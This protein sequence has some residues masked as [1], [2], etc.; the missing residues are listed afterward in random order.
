MLR[1]VD[2]HDA[3]GTFDMQLLQVAAAQAHFDELRRAARVAGA[4][5]PS[6]ATSSSATPTAHQQHDYVR[7]V[8][9]ELK[10]NGK[11]IGGTS[12]PGQR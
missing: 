12:E 6:P 8:V 11:P 3:Q 1:Q 2:H 7:P 10:R 5:S 4:W 9:R